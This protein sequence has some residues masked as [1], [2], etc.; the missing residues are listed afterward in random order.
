LLSSHADLRA[1]VTY[2]ERMQAAA[3]TLGMVVDAPQ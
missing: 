2:D 1:V 3:V